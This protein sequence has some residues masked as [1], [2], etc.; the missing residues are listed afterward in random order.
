MNQLDKED[1]QKLVGDGGNNACRE[2]KLSL[3]RA[4]NIFTPTLLL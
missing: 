4:K 1:L 2:L 3:S